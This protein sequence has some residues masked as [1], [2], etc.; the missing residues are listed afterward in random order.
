MLMS[1]GKVQPTVENVSNVYSLAQKNQHGPEL[2]LASVSNR[3][4]LQST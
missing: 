3:V 2:S 4:Q 1:I